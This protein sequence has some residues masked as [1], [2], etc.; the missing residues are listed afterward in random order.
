MSPLLGLK[1][2]VSRGIPV[3]LVPYS[4]CL[5]IQASKSSQSLRF[6]VNI[7]NKPMYGTAS[8][9]TQP[10]YESFEDVVSGERQTI[11]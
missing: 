3:K 7:K 11:A 10:L 5:A 2:S 9:S 6:L 8:T 4:L 1:T